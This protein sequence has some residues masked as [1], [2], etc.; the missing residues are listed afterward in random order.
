MR[1]QNQRREAKLSYIFIAWNSVVIIRELLLSA[2]IGRC[3]RLLIREFIDLVRVRFD[4][5]LFF[6]IPFS[7]S[8]GFY[9]YVP[10]QRRSES[11]LV[12]IV[13]AQCALGMPIFEY[14]F[15][16]QRRCKRFS[17][18]ICFTCA[19]VSVCRFVLS[20]FLKR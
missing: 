5:F 11:E 6:Q 13:C 14:S 18:F 16:F 17:F 8:T 12:W 9:S 4:F 15:I 3:E 19:L 10:I 20:I 2:C 1:G 7:S